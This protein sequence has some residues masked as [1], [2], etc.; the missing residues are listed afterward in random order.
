MGARTCYL[1]TR[2]CG[3]RWRKVPR[4][5]RQTNLREK[6]GHRG[7]LEALRTP[8]L[9]AAAGLG[10]KRLGARPAV[11]V[12]I[13]FR[14]LMNELPVVQRRE[15]QQEGT[16]YEQSGRLVVYRP[17]PGA[18]A[19]GQPEAVGARATPCAKDQR[20]GA[21]DEQCNRAC[22]ETHRRAPGACGGCPPNR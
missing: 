16:R 17:A 21:P 18:T 14:R 1:S 10:D 5:A 20:G 3:V 7:N 13:P 9:G 4:G 22:R 15:H 8:R 19:G 2:P 12:T 11:H 6:R